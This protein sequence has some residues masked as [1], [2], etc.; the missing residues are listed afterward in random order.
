MVIN[1][2][3]Y[4]K[5]RKMNIHIITPFYRKYLVKTLVHYLRPM[6]I[7]WI[8][9]CDPVDIQGFANV[10]EPWI[11]PLLCPPLNLSRDQSYKKINDYLDKGYLILNEDGNQV[12]YKFNII[13]NEIKLPISKKLNISYF[14]NDKD[15][16]E[17]L[18][19]LIEDYNEQFKHWII[20]NPKNI[21]RIKL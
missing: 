9:M 17:G 21:E 12:R 18:Y 14:T 4:I 1:L 2:K 5:E 6:G 11:H 16:D 13:E 15:A 3:N 7:E 19:T 10:D 20:V 8:P